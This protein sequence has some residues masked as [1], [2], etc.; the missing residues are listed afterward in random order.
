MNL[1][2]PLDGNYTPI[3]NTTVSDNLSFK[4]FIT[5]QFSMEE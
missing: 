4:E 2:T 3:L 5:N 1:T